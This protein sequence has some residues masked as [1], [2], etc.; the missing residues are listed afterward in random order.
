MAEYEGDRGTP[1]GRFVLVAARFNDF[2]VD[3]LVEGARSA[4]LSHGVEE[5]DIDVVRVP[6]A[7]ELAVVADRLA[8]S[9]QYVAIIALGCVIKG[10]TDHY[11]VVVNQS[12]AGLTQVALRT[13]IPVLNAVLTTHT[14]EQAIHRAG[15]K[16]GNKGFEAALAAIETVNLLAELPGAET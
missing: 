3:R 15:A 11:D 1:E 7:L 5:V 14:L 2:I 6:G 4:L 12:A 10:D 8:T 16:S 13:G 9:D